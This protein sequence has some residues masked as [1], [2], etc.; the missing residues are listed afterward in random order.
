MDLHR[1]D[2]SN[3]EE[4]VAMA[5]NIHV[6]RKNEEI[7]SQRQKLIPEGKEVR[8]HI[9]NISIR[10][11][12]IS[13]EIK[14]LRYRR[15]INMRSKTEEKKYNRGLLLTNGELKSVLKTYQK[16]IKEREHLVKQEYLQGVQQLRLEEIEN[17]YELE[18]SR[19]RTY[20]HNF[21]S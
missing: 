17:D 10:V 4:Y 20:L 7:N 1:F 15:K 12:N 14:R 6:E 5:G 13:E 21:T 18:R 16:L 2:K 3:E 9:Q 11:E 8:S 19:D